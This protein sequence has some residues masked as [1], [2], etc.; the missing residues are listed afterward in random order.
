MGAELF[1]RLAGPS[2]GAAATPAGRGR[3]AAGSAGTHA[4]ALAI[5]GGY[6]VCNSAGLSWTLAGHGGET[7]PFWPSG[8]EAGAGSLRLWSKNGRPSC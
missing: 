3:E 2:A 7:R 1:E 5:S 4:A 6:T 8:P